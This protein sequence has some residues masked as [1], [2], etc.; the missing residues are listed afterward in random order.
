MADNTFLSNLVIYT[1]TDFEQTFVLEEEHSNSALN[2][3][4]YTGA[5]NIRKYEGSKIAGTF[6]V[7][8]TNRSLGKVRVSLGSTQT[9]A[10]KEGK[11][12]Y[13]LLLNSGTKVTRVIEGNVVVKQ[14]VTQ[15]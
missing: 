11:Y 15:I 5:A 10:L 2:L 6:L 14:S 4:N 1:G 13:D 7:S 3:N 8:F 9:S 12:F